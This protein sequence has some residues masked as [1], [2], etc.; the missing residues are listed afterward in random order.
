MTKAAFDKI[1][2]GLDDVRHYLD[3]LVDKGDRV[4]ASTDAKVSPT[5]TQAQARPP[6]EA[7]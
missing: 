4:S 7:S 5:S 2:A 1:K 6:K 3:G